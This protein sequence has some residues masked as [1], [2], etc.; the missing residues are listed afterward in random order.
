MN[1][2]IETLD[3]KAKQARENLIATI[4]LDASATLLADD[5]IIASVAMMTYQLALAEKQQSTCK[6]PQE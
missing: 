2:T 5:I 1:K 3:L 6:A 4:K